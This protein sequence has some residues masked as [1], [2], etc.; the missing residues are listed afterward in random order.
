[1]PAALV[2][3]PE[4]LVPLSQPTSAKQAT[5]AI[6][7][8]SFIVLCI[9]FIVSCPSLPGRLA[10][11]GY[12]PNRLR[13]PSIYFGPFGPDPVR[14]RTELW[15]SLGDGEDG[16][17]KIEDAGALGETHPTFGWWRSWL[18]CRATVRLRQTLGQ[19]LAR[20]G[21]PGLKPGRSC[22]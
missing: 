8:S 9:C 22:S 18:I 13:L 5:S 19:E 20:S 4:V 1:V 21:K 12:S 14:C 2:P 3:V 6:N 10:W 7:E 17:F 16:G 11:S 15:R